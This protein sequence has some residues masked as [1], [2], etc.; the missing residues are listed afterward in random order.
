MSRIGRLP[1]TV[2]A[3]V[4]VKVKGSEVLV[5]GPKGEMKRLFSPKIS[6]K[7]EGDQVL[8]TRDSDEPKT[9]SLHGTTRA[10]IN[11][12][13]TGVSTG[14]SKVLEVQGVG[15]RIELDGDNITLHVG[16]SHPVI[17]E[18]PDGITFE[19][20]TRARQ[21]KVLGYDKEIVGQIA[22]NIRKVRPPEPY[23][24]KGIRYQ[25]EKVR[26]KAGKTAKAE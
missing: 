8:I 6:I 22:A 1:V 21:L 18:P 12:M 13:V 15:Y 23:K 5:K 9:R 10:V 11:N 2:P 26:R 3:G 25:G 24:G 20:D 7:M 14:F 19:V 17:V 4:D 16:Y